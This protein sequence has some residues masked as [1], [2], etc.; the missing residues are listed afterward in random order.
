MKVLLLHGDDLYTSRERFNHERESALGEI[1]SLDGKR[2]S[3]SQLVQ[4]LESQSLLEA[5]RTVLIESLLSKGSAEVIAGF[6]KIINQEGPK[7]ILWEDRQIPARHQKKLPQ[8]QMVEFKLPK[9]IFKYLESLR[10]NNAQE[11]LA[12]LR[13]NLNLSDPG[14][15][16]NMVIW[17]LRHLLI[18]RGKEFGQFYPLSPWRQKRLKRHSSCFTF[19]QLKSLYERLL[20]IDVK[21]KSGGISSLEQELVS[22][23][24][25]AAL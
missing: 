17:H 20:G 21:R 10:P 2:I 14:Y 7:V 13:K 12:L 3:L 25:A 15:V 8:A 11:S 1:I 19:R 24:L 18:I 6:F 4:A 9:L 23:T 22:F 5:E 16:F